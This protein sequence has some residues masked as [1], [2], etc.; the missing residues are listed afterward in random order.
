MSWKQ[1][2]NSGYFGMSWNGVKL[3]G[4]QPGFFGQGTAGTVRTSTPGNFGQ[5]GNKGAG[6][7][8]EGGSL[9]TDPAFYGQGDR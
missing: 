5:G 9:R 2:S 1:T 3:E 8:G 7:Y 4:S 6:Y